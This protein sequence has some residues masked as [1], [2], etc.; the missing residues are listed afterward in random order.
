MKG[1]CGGGIPGT[2]IEGDVHNIDTVNLTHCG[3]E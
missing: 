1:R 2:E 3:V